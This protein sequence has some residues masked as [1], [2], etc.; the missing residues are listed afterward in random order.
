[1]KYFHVQVEMY[2]PFDKKRFLAEAFDYDQDRIIKEIVEPYLSLKE[3]FVSGRRIQNQYVEKLKIIQTENPI[4]TMVAEKQRLVPKGVI[5]VITP[6]DF[7][8]DSV[9]HVKDVTF[10]LINGTR[11]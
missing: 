5:M 3:F 7:F 2:S 10:E 1:M 9:A 4:Q 6:S 8:G 11:N